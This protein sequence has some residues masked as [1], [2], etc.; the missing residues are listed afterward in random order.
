MAFKVFNELL[1]L[2]PDKVADYTLPYI[3]TV[4]GS[5]RL[6]RII[7]LA[8]KYLA[9]HNRSQVKILEAWEDTDHL[10]QWFFE[11][12]ASEKRS[13]IDKHFASDENLIESHV[14]NEIEALKLSYISDVDVLEAIL[15]YED[16]G[17]F[18][19]IP[20][21]KT[22]FSN[23]E[24]FCVMA[25]FLAS[26]AIGALQEARALIDNGVGTDNQHDL[27]EVSRLFEEAKDASVDAQVA[28]D[29]AKYHDALTSTEFLELVKDWISEQNRAHAQKRN[30]KHRMRQE[31]AWKLF[32]EA[33]KK[34][35]TQNKEQKPKRSNL[36]ASIVEQVQEYSDEIHLKRLTVGSEIDTIDRLLRRYEAELKKQSNK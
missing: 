33:E 16:Y 13:E 1:S 15:Q 2:S 26:I 31:F 34:A 30:V 4:D 3:R 28:I 8:L 20:V 9:Q 24:F 27:S 7:Y 36:I 19:D 25:L 23:V 17:S 35:L 22:D 5:L 14:T 6:K 32:V 11:K 18:S 29:L 10:C 12:R 21:V